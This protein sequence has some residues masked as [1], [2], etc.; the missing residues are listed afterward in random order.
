MYDDLGGGVRSGIGSA[1]IGKS[2]ASIGASMGAFAGMAASGGFE[3]NESGGQALLNAIKRMREWATDQELTL[4]DLAQP[5]PLGS[6]ST[7]KIMVPYLQQVAADNQGFL[8]QL[9]QFQESLHKAEEGINTAMANYRA[10]EE[11]KAAAM[12]KIDPV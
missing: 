3:V 4:A 7:A 8:T 12:R 1:D 11:A 9:A 5:M 10:T 6:T 2:I